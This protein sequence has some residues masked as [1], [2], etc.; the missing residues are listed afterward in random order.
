MLLPGF[1]ATHGHGD[2]VDTQ[3]TVGAQPGGS[4]LPEGWTAWQG[5]QRSARTPLLLSTKQ[6]VRARP[7]R[8]FSMWRC[9]SVPGSSVSLKSLAGVKLHRGA[10]MRRL[11]WHTVRGKDP[12]CRGRTARCILLGL[13][14]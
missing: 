5:F 10:Q 12:P 1:T 13:L 9:L 7:A 2:V 6:T 8:A 14:C 11:G 4:Q 3:G